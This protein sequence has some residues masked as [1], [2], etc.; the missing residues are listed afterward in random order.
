VRNG[1]PEE[2]ESL[3]V[4]LLA[5]IEDMP[6]EDLAAAGAALDKALGE[7]PES[8]PFESLRGDPDFILP[9]HPRPRYRKF[10]P[11]RLKGRPLSHDVIEDR[12]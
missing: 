12:R 2:P 1:R 8:S 3:R 5:R 6:E 9:K 7:E 10:T 11:V 4:R